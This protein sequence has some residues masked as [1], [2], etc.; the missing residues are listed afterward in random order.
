MAEEPDI[1]WLL[2]RNVFEDNNPERIAQIVRSQG[3]T[4]F[5]VVYT[6]V[7]GDEQQLRPA[8]SVPF[9]HDELVFVYGSMNLCRWLLRDRRWPQ[10]A[11]YDF[12]RLRCQ[13]Y[14]AHWGNFLLQREY[15]FLPLT[16]VHRRRE[17]LFQT[18]GRDGRIFIRPDDNAKSFAGG[19]VEANDF[20][21]WWE[22]ANFYRP[23]P[24]S[25]AVVASPQIIRCEW[26][27]IIGHKK[28]VTGSQYR[29]NGVEELLASYPP[30]AAGFA[31]AVASFNG[32]EPHPV[33]VMDVC[34]TSDGYRLVE[35]GSIC[36][37]SLY[38]CDLDRVIAAI[39]EGQR[40]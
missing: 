11:W 28:V 4:C 13:S 19:V 14:Y 20:E 27:F 26:R 21:K 2:E 23:S 16:E 24:E 29:R 15:A 9:A 30:E 10:L 31:E 25:I 6:C 5:E 3:M 18:F 1:K 7:D 36:C 35:I 37:A 38:A 39:T 40:G 33:Y 22:L 32:F 34:E 17:W 12:G 8:A